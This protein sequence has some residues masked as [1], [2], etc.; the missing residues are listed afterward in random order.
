MF[1]TT[2]VPT[3]SSCPECGCADVE[4]MGKARNDYQFLC[5][6]GHRFEV[7]RGPGLFARWRE[8]RRTR[9]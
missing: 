4:R 5:I 3:P 6:E 7:P 9:T 1:V 2:R 8:K